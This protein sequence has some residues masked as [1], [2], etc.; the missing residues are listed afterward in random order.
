MEPV[1]KGS[2]DHSDS[3]EDLRAAIRLEAPPSA[4]HLG[5]GFRVILRVTR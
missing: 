5:F 3:A 1:L 2:G 4:I